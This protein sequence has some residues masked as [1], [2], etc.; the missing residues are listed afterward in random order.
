MI[1]P[2]SSITIAPS[3]SAT[4]GNRARNVGPSHH[5]VVARRP[6]STPASAST[7]LAAHAPATRAPAARHRAISAAASRT[8][9]RARISSTRAGTSALIAGTI[10]SSGRCL[11]DA[12]GT[13]SPWPVRTRRRTPIRAT[14]N[15]G[16]APA[17][18]FAIASVSWIAASPM[19]N[20]PSSARMA[21][22]M[23]ETISSLSIPTLGEPPVRA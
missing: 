19:S 16:R 7:K 6:S 17:S 3:S 11:T 8:S 14:R 1:T 5:V 9:G 4:R 18:A 12:T 23:S 13:S 21:T 2:P 20:T 15:G 10:T 22:S